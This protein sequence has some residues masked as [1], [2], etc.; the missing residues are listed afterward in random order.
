LQV[1]A[2]SKNHEIAIIE[3]Q[4]LVI[5]VYKNQSTFIM[6]FKLS[7]SQENDLLRQPET[8]MGYQIV[9][10]SKEGSYTRENFLVLNSEIA[11]EMDSSEADNI[12]QIINK[13]IFKVKSSAS[14]IILNRL[15]VLNKKEFR[16]IVKESKNENERGA[17]E[18]PVEKANGEEIFARLSAFE[19]DRRVDKTKKCL[20]PGSFTTMLDDY[21][22]CKTKKDDPV[23]RY[24]LP[25]ND[26]IKFV[27]YIQPLKTDTLQRGT[28]QPANEK[29]GGGKEAYF[30]Q[31][32]A[33]DT[34]IGQILY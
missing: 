28:V 27:F 33:A 19:N 23:E 34:F 3:E 32:T 12:R 26:D 22:T 15:S 16:S 18:N 6:Y 11:I 24:A 4:L 1:I 13:G 8:G 5:F 29:R 17:I 20:R 30:D 9:E 2:V 10:A 14:I 7:T 31:G 21:I 25:N